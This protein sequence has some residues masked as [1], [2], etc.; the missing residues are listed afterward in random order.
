MDAPTDI[1]SDRCRVC[2]TRVVVTSADEVVIRNAILK[3]DLPTG[4]VSAKC[5]RCKSW[6]EV[7]LRYVG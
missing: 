6:L 1:P 2:H 5:T 7:P 4:R 3:V